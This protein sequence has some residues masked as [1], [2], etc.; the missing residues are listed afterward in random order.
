[1][2][3]WAPRFIAPD[4]DSDPARVVR[5]RAALAPAISGD[6]IVRA[7]LRLTA[8]GV[9]E[10][11]LDGAQIGSSVLTPGWSSYQWRLR[12]AEHDLD[13]HLLNAGSVLEL[14]LG[15]GW[16]AGRLGFYGSRL[17]P[18]ASARTS[19]TVRTSTPGSA[20]RRPGGR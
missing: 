13:P 9:V 5:M 20:I 18:P 10:A 11:R 15:A 7:V 1:V 8:L 4:G 12:Y 16:Y 19:M 6:M 17:R 14:D 3:S 2:L